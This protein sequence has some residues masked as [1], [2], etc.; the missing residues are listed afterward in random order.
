MKCC[1]VGEGKRVII[2]NHKHGNLMES[3]L[4][5]ELSD[6]SSGDLSEREQFLSWRPHCKPALSQNCWWYTSLMFFDPTLRTSFRVKG[7]MLTYMDSMRG[8]GAHFECRLALV[9]LEP[10]QILSDSLLDSALATEKV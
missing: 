2:G 3:M 6:T 4:R 8:V 9:S 7:I 1:L 5:R 10:F